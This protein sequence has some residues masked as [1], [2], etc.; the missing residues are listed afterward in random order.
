[1]CYLAEEHAAGDKGIGIHSNIHT[2]Q[3]NSIETAPINRHPFKGLELRMDVLRVHHTALG[4]GHERESQQC[5][6]QVKLQEP[7]MFGAG[8]WG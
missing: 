2:V 1:V 8:A 6:R 3:Q 5:R 4:A 7:G